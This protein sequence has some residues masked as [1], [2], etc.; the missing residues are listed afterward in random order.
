M[1]ELAW[2]TIPM[3]TGWSAFV[4]TTTNPTITTTERHLLK[5]DVVAS[6]LHFAIS[7]STGYV[8]A[9]SSREDTN[10]IEGDQL[11]SNLNS[12]PT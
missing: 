10:H 1:K 12:R 2:S 7:P 4:H 3:A 6:D 8:Q 5:D 11:D 9:T